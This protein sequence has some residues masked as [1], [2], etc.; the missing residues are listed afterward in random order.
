MANTVCG[1][2][3]APGAKECNEFTE[4]ADKIIAEKKPTYTV[5]IEWFEALS[6]ALKA[7][8]K[9]ITQTKR[10]EELRKAMGNIFF[11]EQKE[12]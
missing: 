10:E 6:A 8:A 9:K 4:L 3:I 1:I 5:P 2:G 12:G 7:E 11:P